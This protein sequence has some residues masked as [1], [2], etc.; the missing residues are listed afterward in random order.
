M[1]ADRKRGEPECKEAS[2]TAK[3]KPPSASAGDTERGAAGLLE[4]VADANSVATPVT[5]SARLSK[6]SWAKAEGWKQQEAK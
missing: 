6:E 3:W 4:I 2:G 5:A 1:A